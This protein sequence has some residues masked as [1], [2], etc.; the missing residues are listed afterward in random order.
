VGWLT[1]L[2]Y[3]FISVAFNGEAGLCSFTAR[4]LTCAG[5]CNTVG[6]AKRRRREEVMRIVGGVFEI[7]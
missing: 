7:F 5:G 1:D 2:A 6:T 3:L 4:F